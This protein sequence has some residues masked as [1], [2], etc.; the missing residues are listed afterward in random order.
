MQW[1]EHAFILLSLHCV[2][3]ILGHR[4]AHRV[5]HED[6]CFASVDSFHGYPHS[7]LASATPAVLAT[8]I[9]EQLQELGSQRIL[10]R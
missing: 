7:C 2:V 8:E 3:R 10:E 4:D 6:I 9:I 1:P 5:L